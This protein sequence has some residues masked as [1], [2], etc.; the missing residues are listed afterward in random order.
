MSTFK[1]VLRVAAAHPL[2]LLIYTVLVSC[3]GVFV[4]RAS[5]DTTARTSAAAYE[6][7]GAD[8]AVVD[9]DGS[10]LSKAF[11]EH[12]DGRFNAVEL[13]D[14]AAVL[15]GALATSQVDCILFV[16][17]GFGRDLL[18]AA[19]DGSD[20]PQVEE[21]YGSATQ[22]SALVGAE[23]ERWVSLAGSAAALDT[24]GD[25]DAVARR[26]GDAASERADVTV[27]APRAV[28]WSASDQVALYLKFNSYAITSSIITIVGL[29]LSTMTEPDLKRRLEAGPQA[30]R[31]RSA[32]TLSGCLVITLVICALST[33][34]GIVG[35]FE[36]VSSLHMWQIV[37][38]FGANLALGLVTL[39]I[40]FLCSQLGAR[41]EVLHAVGNVLGMLMSF[42]GGAWVPLS[43]MGAGVVA[44]A[45]FVPTYW[46]N[47]AVDAA[48]GTTAFSW[49]ALAGY[50]ANIGITLLF[51]VAI[52][53]VGLSVAGARRREL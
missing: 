42:M 41:E 8:I 12:M 48:L 33:L 20:L 10:A 14:D 50:G 7:Y 47:G 1:T 19:R 13:E 21:A 34:V 18:A 4:A 45:H 28:G 49:S 5:Y 3:M 27:H 40:A 25:Q 26:V 30:A 11:A 29:V 23:A 16:P 35:L 39:S 9:R 53:A 6:P 52:G 51:A 38:S 46:V 31:S 2:Y 17:E 44:A 32:S 37:L 36:S 43:F 24:G 15:Q 22:T